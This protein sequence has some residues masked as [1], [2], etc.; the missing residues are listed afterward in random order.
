MPRKSSAHTELD[1]LEQRVAEATLALREAEAKRAASEAAVETARDA[2]REAHDLGTDPG[3]AFEA[4]E[5]AKLDAEQAA[6]AAE[7]VAQRVRRAEQEKKPTVAKLPGKGTSAK[8]TDF[9]AQPGRSAL[10]K[11][12]RKR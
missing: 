8:L 11:G 1:Q 7:G 2:V 6:L 5:Q 12:R 3:E 4:L 10:P 9:L